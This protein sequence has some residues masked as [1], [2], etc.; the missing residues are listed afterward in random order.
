MRSDESTRRE[1]AAA[2]VILLGIGGADLN[3][4]DDALA[5]GS[6]Q[7]RSCYKPVLDAFGHNFDA[8][9]K[10]LSTLRR[11]DS[12]LR[13]ITLANAVPGAGSVIPPFVTA[14]IGLY[15]AEVELQTICGTMSRYGG[16]CVDVLHAFN[17]PSGTDDA[18]STG[19]MNMQDCC[20]PSAKGQQLIAELLQASG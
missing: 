17:G 10:E 2:D 12:M 7:G 14:D 15:Q 4:G 18:Y 5:T 11:P 9:V 3:A 20:Y 8:I 13:A 6:C 1:L 19:L 16:R